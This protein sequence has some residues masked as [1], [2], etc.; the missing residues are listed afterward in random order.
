MISYLLF[1]LLGFATGATAVA[2]YFIP[3]IKQHV[4]DEVQSIRDAV[5]AARKPKG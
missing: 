5:A 2:F 1:F 4:T 3:G